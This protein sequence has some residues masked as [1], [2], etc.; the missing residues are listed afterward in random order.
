MG[1]VMQRWYWKKMSDGSRKR[2]KTTAWYAEWQEGG[3]T[4]RRKIGPKAAAT[5]AL[6][7]F[8]EAAVRRKHGLSD[9]TAEAA[10]RARPL[11]QYLV[12][13][14]ET[15]AARDTSPD[16]RANVRARLAL[17]LSECRWHLFRD[18]DPDALLLFLGRLRDRPRAP[19]L[20]GAA[21]KAGGRTHSKRAPARGLAPTTLN[22]YIRTAQA[23]T[24][25]VARK[26]R[27]DPPLA[28]VEFYPEEVDRRRSKQVLTDA[29]LGR[30]L[31]STAAARHK[32]NCPV[33]GADRA[34]LYR[35]GA[36]TG[37]RAGE[38][39]ELT[40]RHFALDASPPVVTVPA[41]EA[42]GK[43]EEPIP[44]PA[45]LA[46]LLRPWLGGFAPT[47][48][49][50]PG[51]WAHHK[52]ESKWLASDLKRAGVDARDEQGRG[53]TF[54]SLKRRYVVRLIHAGAKVHEVR[55]LARHTDVRTTL[56]HYVDENMLDLAALADRL[57]PV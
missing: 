45:H 11:A 12:E 41:D 19:A 33:R 42:K 15:L 37:L 27:A 34:M 54:H 2:V 8:E 40:P 6:A 35:I 26:V 55:R 46:D 28:A 18:V 13:Y 24:R 23:F 1:R 44:L 7:K 30:L 5:A 43:R 39:A 49:L 21:K 52:H 50:F 38:L 20:R 53:V 48:R 25:W 56:Q 51:T 32:W 17:V 9:P 16:H 14:L 22:G 36:Y 4:R 57:P 29:Q 47:A 3:E 31:A 10:A